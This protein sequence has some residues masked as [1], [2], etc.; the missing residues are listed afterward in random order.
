MPVEVVGLR[1]ALIAMR[2]LEPS[3]AKD[4]KKEITNILNP[5][6]KDARNYVLSSPPGLSH[7][8]HNPK[9]HSITQKSSMFRI[10]PM[11]NA[12]EVRR[13]I[14]SE[15][16]P[17]KPKPNGWQS[18]VRIVNSSRAGAIY[19][20]AGK[21]NPAGQPWRGR[22]DYGN[23]KVSHS[24]NP[25]AGLHFINSL[26]RLHGSK[27][28]RGRL[29]Y[30]AWDEDQGRALAKVMKAIEKSAQRTQTFLDSANALRNAA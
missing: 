17:T 14:K 7:W 19:E 11:F 2:K 18:L 26:G 8:V 23:H 5:I 12:A 21:L 4:V 13:G 24:I 6:V 9:D 1:E 16:F 29:I 15:V 10:F 22:K 28:D 30:R 3:L 27:Q 25:N 20:T